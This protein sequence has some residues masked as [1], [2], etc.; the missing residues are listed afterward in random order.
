M[1]LCRTFRETVI[2]ARSPVF[3]HLSTSLYGLSTIRAFNAQRTFERMFDLKQDHHTSAWYMFL[4]T[5]RWFGIT[6]D[7]ICFAYITIVTMSLALSSDGGFAF[8]SYNS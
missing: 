4:C 2:R 8:A 3:S 1:R 7:S 5:A 6:L